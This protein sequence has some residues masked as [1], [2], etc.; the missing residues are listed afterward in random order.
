MHIDSKLLR[1]NPLTICLAAALALGEPLLA[2]APSTAAGHAAAARTASLVAHPPLARTQTPARRAPRPD[3]ITVLEVSNCADSG[4]GSLRDVIAGAADGNAVDL[5]ALTCSTITLTSGAIEF[6]T[7]HLYLYSLHRGAVTIDGAGQS[8][9]FRHNTATGGRLTVYGFDLANGSTEGDGGCIDSNGEVDLYY[10]RVSNCHAHTTTDEVHGGAVSS[11]QDVRATGSTITSSTAY[12]DSNFAKGGGVYAGG[13][14][15]LVSTTISGNIA[16][17][18]TTRSFGGGAF[19]KGFSYIAQTTIEGNNAYNVGGIAFVGGANYSVDVYSST[20]SGNTANGFMGGMYSSVQLTVR[21][22]TIAFNCAGS[23]LIAPGYISAIG[24]QNYYTAPYLQNTIIA[25]NDLCPA[26]RGAGVILDTP[27]DVSVYGPNPIL[28]DHNLIV[29]SAV[30]LPTGTLRIDPQLAPLADN[31]GPTRTHAL[32][33]T[34]PAIN[35]GYAP[36]VVFDQRGRWFAR[37]IGPLADIGA[38]EVQGVGPTRLVTNCADSG[39]GS[40]RDIVSRAQSGDSVDLSS[41]ACSTITLGG[42]IAIPQGNLRLIGPGSTSLTIDAAGAGRVFHHT[43]GGTLQIEGMSLVNGIAGPEYAT[44][45]CLVSYGRVLGDDV[46]LAGCKATSSASES[47][48]GGAAYAFDLEL[49]NSLVTNNMS[50]A[51]NGEA[52]GGGIAADYLVL[53]RTTVSGNIATAT[54][55]ESYGGGFFGSRTQT[56]T[57]TTISGNSAATGGGAFFN[58]LT[59]TNSTLSGNSASRQGGGAYGYVLRMFN[60]TVTANNNS[61]ALAP[62]VGGLFAEISAEIESSILFGNTVASKPFDFDGATLDGSHDVIGNSTIVVPP[63]T[64]GDDPLLGPLQDNGGPTFTHALLEGSPAIDAGSNPTHVVDDQRGDGFQRVIGLA[65][66]IGAF[67]VQS[68]APD[69]RI[70]SDGFDPQARH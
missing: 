6:A 17:S 21:N 3:G 30:A 14:L 45:G 13:T 59:I 70:F 9:I 32:Q 25:D 49:A 50:L 33:P 60:S 16:R 43:G 54:G 36:S 44:G 34:S 20:I 2:A 26:A 37:I 19:V 67:E 7:P 38:Y 63:D 23:T 8:R 40:L 65:P 10:S 1:K 57:N 41:L 58:N 29:T 4:L 53:D 69:E 22:S 55:D 46:T 28:G 56:V 42:E 5:S 51:E 48:F 11:T 35:A 52:V 66:D 15:D 47:S 39:D 62:G 18:D 61:G 27:Y 68:V 64:I 31:G 24:L 12:S